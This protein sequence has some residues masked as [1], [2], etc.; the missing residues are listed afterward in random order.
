MADEG[1]V[2]ARHEPAVE[3]V[4]VAMIMIV[5]RGSTKRGERRGRDISL[6]TIT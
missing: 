5:I 2:Q 1:D 4:V 3:V 6:N